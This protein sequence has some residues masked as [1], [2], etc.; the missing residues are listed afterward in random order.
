[1][2]QNDIEQLIQ[3]GELW[4]N[5]SNWLSHNVLMAYQETFGD[6]QALST[7]RDWLATIIARLIC[8]DAE[9]RAVFWE[10]LNSSKPIAQEPVSQGRKGNPGKIWKRIMGWL[11]EKEIL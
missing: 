1:M 9:K 5:L 11:C 3:D 6:V 8:S 10:H 2:E 7:S 4:D